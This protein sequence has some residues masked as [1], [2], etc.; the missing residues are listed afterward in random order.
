MDHSHQPPQRSTQQNAAPQ[1]EPQPETPEVFQQARQ[2]ARPQA[3]QS[4][5]PP[6]R[7]LRD[8]AL[9]ASIWERQ[10]GEG[11]SYSTKVVRKWRDDAGQFHESN[12]YSE[13][14]LPRL[15]DLARN[16]SDVISGLKQGR[17]Q[18]APRFGEEQPPQTSAQQDYLQE[19]QQPAGPTNGRRQRR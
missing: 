18:E 17:Q 7:T 5:E 10:N 11:P 12:S 1:A 2:Q 19:R 13:Y 6:V 4:P 3:A 14:D 8:G 9:S 15:A 16:A